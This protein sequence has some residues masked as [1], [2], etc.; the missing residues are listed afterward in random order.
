MRLRIIA[1]TIPVG[2]GGAG[3]YLSYIAKVHADHFL[4]APW[5][6]GRFKKPKGLQIAVYAFEVLVIKMMLYLLTSLGMISSVA[7]HHPQ[8]LGY[9]LTRRLISGAKKVD[10]WVL[11]AS[12]FC[13]RSYN[14]HDQKSCTKCLQVYNPYPDCRHFPNHFVSRNAYLKFRLC[15]R[16][17]QDKIIFHVQT[18]GYQRLIAEGFT[19]IN[20]VVKEKMLV[21]S[22]NA[23]AVPSSQGHK[24]DFLFHANPLSAKGFDYF[25]ALSKFLRHRVFFVP[26]ARSVAVGEF[27]NVRF[28]DVTWSSGLQESVAQSKVVLC[29]SLWS[30]PVEAAVVKSCLLGKPVGLIASE[31]SFANEIPEDCF[32]R[33]SGEPSADA[34][35]LER[36]VTNDAKLARIAAAGR[37]WAAGYIDGSV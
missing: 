14:H 19:G 3:D 34:T 36:M 28:E 20:V 11:D 33:L 30:A 13:K 29:P 21:P 18:D 31:Y 6:A 32:V 27:T 35:I 4:I 5:L 9:R 22:F 26:S 17:N 15:L 37:K 16:D 24:Y 1:S 25:L 7:I 10:Y 23:A 12:F 8:S 2:Y